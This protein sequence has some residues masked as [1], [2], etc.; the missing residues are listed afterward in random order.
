MLKMLSGRTLPPDRQASV[1]GKPSQTKQVV[2]H[3]ERG[4]QVH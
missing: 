1:Q 4:L 2:C 3:C